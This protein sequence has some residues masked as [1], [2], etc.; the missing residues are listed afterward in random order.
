MPTSWKF[1]YSYIF[2]HYDVNLVEQEN[3]QKI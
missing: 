3:K 1:L 2:A